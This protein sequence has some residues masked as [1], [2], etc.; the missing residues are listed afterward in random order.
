MIRRLCRCPGCQA[1]Q[2]VRRLPE[3]M[4]AL[5]I[6]MKYLE[7]TADSKLVH[8]PAVV[9]GLQLGGILCK[10]VGVSQIWVTTEERDVK[11]PASL[12][13]APSAI[14]QLVESYLQLHVLQDGGGLSLSCR[15]VDGSMGGT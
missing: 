14:I 15:D 5:T 6:I 13:E 9:R 7:H 11:F 3:L 12:N 4:R 8:A 2:A 10:A 1:G